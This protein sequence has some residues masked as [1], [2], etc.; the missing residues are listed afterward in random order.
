MHGLGFWRLRNLIL[1]FKRVYFGRALVQGFGFGN[2][3]L[4]MKVEGDCLEKGKWQESGQ[5]GNIYRTTI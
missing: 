4:R 1:G 3:G 2:K 5:V